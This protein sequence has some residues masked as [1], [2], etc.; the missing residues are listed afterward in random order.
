[1]LY[2]KTSADRIGCSRVSPPAVK[3]RD[4]GSVGQVGVQISPAP[5]S[6]LDSERQVESSGQDSQL[7]PDA[8]IAHQARE[9]RVLG[10]SQRM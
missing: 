2:L 8:E 3:R 10:W 6:R 5:R 4:Q 1:M 7:G 9:V